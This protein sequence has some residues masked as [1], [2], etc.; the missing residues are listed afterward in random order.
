MTKGA[1]AAAVRGGGDWLMRAVPTHL[2]VVP[3]HDASDAAQTIQLPAN[4]KRRG[5][6]VQLGPQ[7][8]P[9]EEAPRKDLVPKG[10]KGCRGM[11]WR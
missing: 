4:G 10:F 6:V 1:H 11:G 7:V 5:G 2:L 3:L 9:L 8:L